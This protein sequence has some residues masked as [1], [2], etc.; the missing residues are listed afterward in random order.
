M[1]KVI[2]GDTDKSIYNTSVYFNNSYEE[3]WFTDELVKQIV[4]DV[5]KSEIISTN[6]ILSP[7]LGQIPPITLS[8]GTK[9]LILILK[10]QNKVFNASQCGD[11]CAKWILQI[12]KTYDITINLRHIMDFG[13]EPF[14]LF[15]ENTN[16]KVHTMKEL[17]PIAHELLKK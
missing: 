2:F 16:Q 7:V 15:I 9:T 4:K 14:D 13:C 5:D 8:G 11:N 6:C 1:L 3:D 12:S 10:E 17:I